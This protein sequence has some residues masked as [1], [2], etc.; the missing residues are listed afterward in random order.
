MTIDTLKA[1]D[2][3]KKWRWLVLGTLAVGM[4]YFSMGRETNAFVF[5]RL[6]FNSGIAAL[7]SESVQ[8]LDE[9]SAMLNTVPAADKR[10]DEYINTHPMMKR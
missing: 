1:E 5:G 10:P 3:L 8:T 6:H 7:A 4:I 2:G 9:L